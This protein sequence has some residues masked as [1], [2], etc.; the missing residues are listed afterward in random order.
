MHSGATNNAVGIHMDTTAIYDIKHSGCE[1]KPSGRMLF[2]FK[3]RQRMK[4]RI[5]SHGRQ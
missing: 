4:D 1:I 2:V 5:S 3:N